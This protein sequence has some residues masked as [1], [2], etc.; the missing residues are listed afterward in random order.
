MQSTYLRSYAAISPQF[1]EFAGKDVDFRAML[2]H[3]FK[4]ASLLISGE[5]HF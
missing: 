2:R 4:N 1:T 5:A 3:L